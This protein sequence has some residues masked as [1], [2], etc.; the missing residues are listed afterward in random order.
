MNQ[1]FDGYSESFDYS[2]IPK[3]FFSRVMPIINDLDELKTTL[4]FFKLFFAKKGQP[5]FVTDLELVAEAQGQLD[6]DQIRKAMNLAGQHNH[7]IELNGVNGAKTYFLNDASGRKSV[8]LIKQGEIQVPEVVPA[9]PVAPPI[10]T[11]NIFSLYEQNIGLITPIIADE[12]RSAMDN[13]P[14][15]WIRDAISEASELNKRS[16]R[17]ISKILDNWATQ[18]KRD[19]THQ[20]DIQKGPDKYVKGRYGKFVQR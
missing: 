6:Q 18:G 9:I 7:I 13:Y 10:E 15:T 14:E 12:L 2:G 1:V 11:P 16:W 19:G 17:Y 20:R 8:A 4:I 3:P 5:R